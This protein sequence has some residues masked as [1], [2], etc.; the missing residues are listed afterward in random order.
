VDKITFGPFC[1]SL[2]STRLLRDEIDLGLRPQALH[3]LKVLLQNSGSYVDYERMIREAWDGTLVSRHTVA[4]TVGEVKKALGEYASWI[5]YRPK[6]GYRFEVPRTDDLIRKGWHFWSH[7]TREGLEKALR[8]FREAAWRDAVD[9][10]AY[11]GISLAHLTL[12][13]CGMRHPQTMYAAFLEA[14]QRA[15]ELAGL[16]PELRS[17][18]GHGLHLFER[19][20]G[21]AEV[22]LLRAQQEKPRAATAVRLTMLYAALGRMDD[23]LD[24][25]KDAHGI[26]PLWPMLP[27]AE[28]NIRFLRR[29]FEC[30]VACGQEALELHPYLQMAR[31]FLAQA[32]EY[33]GRVEEALGQ[34]ERACALSGDLPWLRALEGTCLARH[35]WRAKAC[36]I[37][38]ELEQI[39]AADY[40]DGY[41]MALLYDSLGDR[42]Q[43]FQEL[44]RAVADNSGTVTILDADPKMDCLRRDPRFGRLCDTVFAGARPMSCASGRLI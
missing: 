29:E 20:F 6:L 14:H 11:Q 21:D 5:I 38:R 3:A 31:L 26:E 16:T 40:V 12:G 30:A 2:A 18:R 35:G 37:L 34:Y 8:C 36:E 4:V 25:L 15:V 23:A 17:D 10:R 32:L 43:A 19:R 1:L 41:Y 44:E 39:R 24:V 28:I 22:D 13:A 27:A 33:A 9:F 42:D 7:Y